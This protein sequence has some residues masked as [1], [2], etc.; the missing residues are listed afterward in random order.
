M[1]EITPKHDFLVGIDSDGCAFDTMELKHKE[2]FIPNTINF[3]EL[4]SVSKY[5]REAAEFVNLYSKSR[6]I[7]RFPALV[8]TL[9]WLA[10][11]PEVAARNKQITIPPGLVTWIERETRLG[12]PALETAVNETGDPDLKLALDWSV[13]VNNDV[14]GMVRGVAPFPF[15][16]ECLEKLEGRADMLVV[17]ATPEPALKA[18][19]KEND[20]ARFVTAICGQ[21]SGSKTETLTNASKY[22]PHH[23]LMIGDAPGDH[24]AAVANDCLFL[25]INPGAEEASWKRL[26]D[27]GLER[28]LDGAFA[29]DYQ[30]QLLD[31]FNTY[32]PEKPPWE[33]KRSAGPR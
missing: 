16:R 22:P 24:K 33:T 7:N 3:Y 23:T 15:V 12:N 18:E 31:E 2:C 6:G 19:W 4:Q 10:K 26:Y 29:G 32:L 27:E 1:Y 20:I 14:A 5:A 17:S 21:E 8:E 30:Q 9:E 25:P 13:A 28:F 11:R